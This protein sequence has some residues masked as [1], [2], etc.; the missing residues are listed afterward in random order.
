MFD[1]FEW[2][3]AFEPAASN[4]ILT[5][6]NDYDWDEWDRQANEYLK[7]DGYE[8]PDAPAQPGAQQQQPA[9]QEPIELPQVEAPA[10]AAEMPAQLYTPDKT[11]E[12]APQEPVQKGEVSLQEVLDS[13]PQ[14]NR[15]PNGLLARLTGE[16]EQPQ[17]TPMMNPAEPQS[18]ATA[19]ADERVKQQP[20]LTEKPGNQNDQI[21]KGLLSS[22]MGSNAGGQ[23]LAA[24]ITGGF[25]MLKGYGEGATLQKKIENDEKI[26]QQEIARRERN[27]YAGVVPKR[28]Y[29]KG[30]I[31]TA[32]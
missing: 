15:D 8:I 19:L 26:R 12:Q 10:P 32:K 11:E 31:G 24:L 17:S 29:V 9:Q 5:A 13:L 14:Q 20:R 30:L 21:S 7:S 2:I 27:S 16:N 1:S 6:M 23:A 22:L 25:S 18:A 3:S 4:D 28:N